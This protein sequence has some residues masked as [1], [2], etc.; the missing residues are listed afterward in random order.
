MPIYL[1]KESE[2]RNS[3]IASFKYDLTDNDNKEKLNDEDH[4]A[5]IDISIK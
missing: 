4:W 1:C 2:S 3:F 5:G